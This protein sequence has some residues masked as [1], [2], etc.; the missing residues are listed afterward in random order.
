[1]I[2]FLYCIL[3][4]VIET[5]FLALTGYRKPDEI[6]IIICANVLTNLSMNLLLCFIDRST[7]LLIIL[8]LIVIGAEYLI[9]GAVFG[10]CRRLFLLTLAANVISCGIGL[11]IFGA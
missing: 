11:L 1:M 4:V 3:T 7:L 2:L 8:E 9:Y 5:A 6:K 10:R